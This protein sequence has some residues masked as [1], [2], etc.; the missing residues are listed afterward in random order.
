M[1]TDLKQYNKLKTAPQSNNEF[2]ET[3]RLVQITRVSKVTKGGKRLCFRAIVVIGNE[4]GQVGIGVAKATDV[5]NAFQKAKNNAKKNLIAV[6]ITKSSSIPHNISGRFRAA[7][8][9]LRPSFEGSG[10]VAG[11]AVRSVL[12]VA[13]IKNVIAKQLGSNNLLNNARATIIALQNL[14][15]MSQVSQKRHIP[16]E[17]YKNISIKELQLS[18][19][20]YNGLKGAHINTILDLLEQSPEKLTGINYFG[21]K[22]INEIYR[23]LKNKFGITLT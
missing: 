15:T 12:E 16:I 6:P 2:P 14:T 10:V 18:N 5:I 23:A 11:G 1:T 22:S 3:D 21:Q 7:K 9:I 19:R 4:N 13:G 20:I 17:I 8:I